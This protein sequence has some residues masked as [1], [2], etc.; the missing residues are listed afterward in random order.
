M[1]SALPFSPAPVAGES[2]SSWLARLA[3]LYAGSAAGLLR[4][5]GLSVA[6][7]GDR[8]DQ[9]TITYLAEACSLDSQHLDTLTL[10]PES[11]ADS[12]LSRRLSLS[13]PPQRL[14]PFLFFDGSRRYCPVC[15]DA[16]D[17]VWPLTWRVG[18]PICSDHRV[19]LENACSQC[20]AR[21]PSQGV[22]PPARCGVCFTPFR[23]TRPDPAPSTSLLTDLSERIAATRSAY[24]EHCPQD[25]ARLG[26]QAR[27]FTTGNNANLHRADFTEFLVWAEQRGIRLPPV[28]SKVPQ[29]S[30]FTVLSAAPSLKSR[31]PN[32]ART[33]RPD[34]LSVL[35]CQSV[36]AVDE[37]RRQLIAEGQ[38][39]TERAWRRRA[40]QLLRSAASN[41]RETQSVNRFSGR[42]GETPQPVQG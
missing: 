39:L 14:G 32:S 19:W 30:E 12:A 5:F 41:A 3:R 10:G 13:T 20:G 34:P 29:H 33:P 24:P 35:R 36:E 15:L 17:P 18:I 23:T 26:Q 25:W 22:E 16:P 6:Y 42:S 11:Y 37:A 9:A 40:D 2:F 21:L 31:P 4:R 7:D 28:A 38:G 1:T 8:P 27:V